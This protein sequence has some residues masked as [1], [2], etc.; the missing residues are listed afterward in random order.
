VK[1]KFA[2]DIVDS[3]NRLTNAVDLRASRRILRET[4]MVK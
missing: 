4:V 3:R 1:G 2:W